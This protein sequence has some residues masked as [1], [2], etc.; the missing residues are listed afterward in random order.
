MQ[1]RALGAGN[2][3]PQVSVI[4]LGSMTW[5][6][7][8]SEGEAH[9]QM[10]LAVE[11]GVNFIDTAEMYPVPT[12]EPT[13]GLTEAYIG[14]WLG[15]RSDRD[16]L[17]I[18]T[19]AS[20]PN[21]ERFHYLRGGP[22][23][24]ADHMTRALD[25]SLRRLQTD[26]VDLYQIHWPERS[27]N[28]FGKLGFVAQDDADAIP[29]E[30]TLEGLHRLVDSGKIRRV[31][32]S[33]ET[34]WGTM[35]YLQLAEKHGWPRVAS[36]QNPYSLINR[37]YDIGLAEVSYR[38]R[39][40]L[41]AYSPLAFGVLSGKY[42]DGAQPDGAR[43]CRWG[44]QFPRYQQPRALTATKRYVELA[45]QHG[46]DPAQMALAWVNR[47]P[48]V[49]SSIIGATTPEQLASN[50][51]SVDLTLSDDVLAGIEAIHRDDPSPA[52]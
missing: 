21:A 10:D 34:P 28:R 44:D 12:D 7:Q 51:A 24:T 40:G 6:Q 41:L 25:A 8:N 52:P 20:G 39:C 17:F 27:T 35:R 45:Q 9:Q 14:S 2:D 5:G 47:Q 46:L 32:I 30:E 38:E 31:G 4:C 49:T 19:K 15:K 16:R 11:R 43:L 37:T 1:Y 22:R 48:F 23:L 36:I 26:Y 33:N 42:L 18:A 29:L 13:Q 3:A 50:I